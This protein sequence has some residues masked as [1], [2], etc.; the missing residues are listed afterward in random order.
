[1]HNLMTDQSPSILV[2]NNLLQKEIRRFSTLLLVLFKPWNNMAT[3]GIQFVI[4]SIPLCLK[5]SAFSY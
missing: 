3:I 4:L 1:M 5:N 2:R